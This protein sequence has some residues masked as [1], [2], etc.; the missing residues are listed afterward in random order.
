MK[1][2]I[3]Q[4]ILAFLVDIALILILAS[5]VL[6]ISKSLAQP[7]PNYPVD[8]MSEKLKAFYD[9]HKSNFTEAVIY[10]YIS[11]NTEIYNEYVT[12]TNTV[13]YISYTQANIRITA[14]ILIPYISSTLI[15]SI[16]RLSLETIT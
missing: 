5:V 10:E 3:S 1:A 14:S 4:R 11:G 13:E 9:T 7:R 2:T 16:S 15:G 8:A 6:M 12:F